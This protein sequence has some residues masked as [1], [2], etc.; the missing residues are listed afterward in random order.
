MLLYERG[1]KKQRPSEEPELGIVLISSSKISVPCE[2]FLK[3]SAYLAIVAEDLPANAEASGES[4]L[5]RIRPIVEHRVVLY[6][7]ASSLA[8]V[9]RDEVPSPLCHPEYKLF[10][11]PACAPLSMN[12]LVGRH[13]L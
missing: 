3:S 7:K 13:R 6:A 9:G 2:V 5:L 1:G 4:D 10:I 12:N 11:R 8:S